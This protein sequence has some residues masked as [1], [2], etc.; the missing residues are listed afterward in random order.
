M[1]GIPLS[2]IEELSAMTGQMLRVLDTHIILGRTN[3][4]NCV[5]YKPHIP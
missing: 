4:M 2:R 3:V 5:L 1:Q